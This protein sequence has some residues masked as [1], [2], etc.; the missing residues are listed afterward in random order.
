[1]PEP[2]IWG[3]SRKLIEIYGAEAVTTAASRAERLIE[4]GDGQGSQRWQQIAN[5]VE[6]LLNRRHS[7]QGSPSGN[8]C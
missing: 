6:R 7:E 8:G 5:A 3:T 2:D 1:M 4:E